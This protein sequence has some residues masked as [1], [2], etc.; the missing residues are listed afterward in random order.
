MSFFTARV[1]SL[2]ELEN[3][4]VKPRTDGPPMPQTNRPNPPPPE[5]TQ[6]PGPNPQPGT[7]SMY[8]FRNLIVIFP[9]FRCF[10]PLFNLGFLLSLA[11]YLVHLLIGNSILST[12]AS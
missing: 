5:P 12:D 2:S 1:P 10:I 3:G 8:L 7:N 11:F 4:S 9:S 6:G